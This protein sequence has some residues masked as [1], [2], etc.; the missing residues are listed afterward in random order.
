MKK[1]AIILG[2]RPEIIK[3]APIIREC[4]RRG[5]PFII[6]HSGQHY[7]ENLDKIFFE[8]LKL[9]TP[10]Y[11]LN[12]GSLGHINQLAAMMLGFEP[13]FC[14]E[15]LDIVLVQGDTNTVLAGALVSAKLG[16]PIGHVEAGLRS[17]ERSMP[18]EINRIVADHLANYL[19]CPTELQRNILL[20]EGFSPKKVFVVGNTI[21]DSVLTTIELAKDH[22][23]LLDKNGVTPHNFF[24]LTCHR[25]TNTD[26]LENLME[27]LHGVSILAEQEDV[28]CLFPIHPRLNSQRHLFADFPRIRLIAPVGYLES[29]L[30]QSFAR[31]IFTDSGGVQEE[32]CILQKKC[33]V[34]NTTTE[35]PEALSV[36]GAV[37]LPKIHRDEIHSAFSG[38][39][40]KQV[41]W[42]NPFGDGTSA[43]RIMDVLMGAQRQPKTE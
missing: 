13:I 11:N 18:E 35:R 40:D 2:T 27:I 1:I 39:K 28:P 41:R 38:L 36:G 33:I 25:S 6:I 21:V 15:Q 29:L 10:H 34:L 5:L 4:Q 7:D 14:D 31:M 30:L 8:D 24:L 42:E 17:Y 43:S 23:H 3:Q 12:V 9:P 16:I 32:S 19:F 20:S 22:M 37:L 26:K